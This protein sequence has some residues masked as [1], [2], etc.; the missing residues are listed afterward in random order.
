MSRNPKDNVLSAQHHYKLHKMNNFV[1]TQDDFV[2][3]YV[4]DLREI[5]LYFGAAA[6]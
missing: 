5:H 2:D 6:G 3:L 1:G 4:E